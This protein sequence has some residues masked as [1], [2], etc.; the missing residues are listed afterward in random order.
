MNARLNTNFMVFFN[1]ISLSIENDVSRRVT[2][3]LTRDA[4]RNNYSKVKTFRRHH[5]ADLSKLC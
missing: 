5:S 3:N 4:L 2:E 1:E